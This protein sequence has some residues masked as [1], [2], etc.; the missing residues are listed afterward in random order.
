MLRADKILRAERIYEKFSVDKSL[1][2]H[3]EFAIDM[4]DGTHRIHFH[5]YDKKQQ[6]ILNLFVDT[7]DK[8]LIESL[9]YLDSKRNLAYDT[10]ITALIMNY[11]YVFMF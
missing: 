1:T 11:D 3:Y 4:K 2:Y 6:Q 9:E 8:K 5:T 10:N 7:N